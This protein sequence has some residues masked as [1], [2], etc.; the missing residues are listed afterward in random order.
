MKT[1]IEY[2][3]YGPEWE[4]EMK[5]WS[6]DLLIGKL[7]DTFIERA[8]LKDKLADLKDRYND[9]LFTNND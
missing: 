2:E 3:P 4:T 8:E 5:K 9:L 1:E 6:K 7:R